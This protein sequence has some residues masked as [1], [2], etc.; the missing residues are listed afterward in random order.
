MRNIT[1]SMEPT[2]SSSN[3]SKVEKVFDPHL[4]RE[5]MPLHAVYYPLGFP[6]ELWTNSENLMSAAE[7]S[8]GAFRQSLEMKP[9]Q[10]RFGV[11]ESDSTE[12]PL[13]CTCR[14]QQHLFSSISDSENFCM[15]D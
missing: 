11:R 3:E 8:W 15:S 9:L 1:G 12:C 4:S 2:V 6:V 14:A 13:P 10:I 5:E 7:D